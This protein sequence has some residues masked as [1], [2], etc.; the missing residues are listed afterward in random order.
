[1]RWQ[2]G[3]SLRKTPNDYLAIVASAA[4]LAVSIVVW[5]DL[6]FF[7]KVVH[8]PEWA[9]NLPSP[10]YTPAYL[11]LVCLVPATF[12]PSTVSRAVRAVA[13]AVAISP[14]PA[15]FVYIVGAAPRGADFWLNALFNYSWVV[16]FHCLVP[17]LALLAVRGVA[18]TIKGR[19]G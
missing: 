1:M 10:I 18:R 6:F 17:A 16:G 7:S 12:I 11:A 4:L 13:W 3:P 19:D 15:L 5:R 9:T 8:L 14:I 2:F